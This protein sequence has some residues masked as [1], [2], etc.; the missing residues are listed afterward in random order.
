MFVYK[1]G[2][3]ISSKSRVFPF[4]RFTNSKINDFSYLGLFAFVNNTSIGKYCS[5]SM[6]FKSG[7]GTH[8]KTL[9]STSPI[10]YT[11]KYAIKS[12]FGFKRLK[13]VSEYQKITI[14]HDVWI[15]A[16]VIII[17]G[18]K[19]G[20]GA[21]IAAKAV[22]TKDVPNYA[23]VG[24]VPANKIK[25]R[26][27]EDIISKLEELKWWDWSEEKIIRNKEFFRN[28]ITLES[29]NQIKD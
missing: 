26:F 20:N 14:G 5:I 4:S 17:D 29:I 8:P 10:F 21:I 16:D 7:L 1:R 2:S 9:P 3:Q 28:D 6:N 27:S 25:Y 23:I 12:S 13:K 22:V 11:R 15:G 18:V 19:V 24:G